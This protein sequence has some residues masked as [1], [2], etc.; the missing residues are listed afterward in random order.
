MQLFRVFLLILLVFACRPPAETKNIRKTNQTFVLEL[1]AH[2][3]SLP[4]SRAALRTLDPNIVSLGRTL[5]KEP[6]FSRDSSISCASCHQAQKAFSDAPKAFSQGVAGQLGR[7]NSPDLSNLL[8][9]PIYFWDGGGKHLDFTPLRALGD[10]LEMDLSLK[11]LMPRLQSQK[12]Y[13]QAF[14]RA[15]GRTQIQSADVLIA[16]RQY[17]ST[18]ISANSAFDQYFTGDASALSPQAR[19]GWVLFKKNCAPCHRGLLFSDFSFRNNGL[20]KQEKR[21]MGRRRISGLD[22]DMGKYRVP[23]LRNVA[24]TPPYMHDGRFK[25]LRQVLEHYSTGIQTADNVDSLLYF[26]QG[27][28]RFNEKEIRALLVFLENLSDKEDFKP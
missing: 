14:R 12:K 11:Q 4:P 19:S 10:S 24:L 28:F 2:F 8:W 25:T 23:S 16:L 7:V 20:D 15:F 6:L 26:Q 27:G 18:L 22:Q 17:L 13:R 9:R 3:P 21:G 5:F 1:P